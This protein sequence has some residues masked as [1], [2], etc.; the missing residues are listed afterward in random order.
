MQ[1][2]WH[3]ANEYQIITARCARG[4]VCLFVLC[5]RDVSVSGE[6]CCRWYEGRWWW[7]RRQRQ[8]A[9]ALIIRGCFNAVDR[10]RRTTA[11]AR[12]RAGRDPTCCR[13]AAPSTTTPTRPVAWPSWCHRRRSSHTAAPA[14][15]VPR[16]R[17]RVRRPATRARRRGLVSARTVRVR[18]HWVREVVVTC[19]RFRVLV[20][21]SLSHL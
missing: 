5:S 17:T 1:Y 6:S 7:P 19:C 14:S 13:H 15:A 16:P 10:W 9:A 18:P 21:Q 8:A 12:L 11:A 3:L 2:C 20:V 4:E